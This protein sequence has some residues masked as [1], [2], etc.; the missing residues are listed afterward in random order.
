MAEVHR[1][2]LGEVV[3]PDWHPRFRDGTCPILCFAIAHSDGIVVVD[4]GPRAGHPLIDEWFS[5]KI[6]SIVDALNKVE[7]DEREVTAVVNTHLHFDHCGQNEFLPHAPVWVTAEEIEA[8]GAE[9][10]TN[11]EWAAIGEG[12][13]RLSRDDEEIADGVRILHTPGHTPGHQS[14]AVDTTRGLE[15]IVGQACYGCGEFEIGRP[16]ET[17]M[18]DAAWFKPGLESLRRLKSLD[19]VVS[20]FSHDVAIFRR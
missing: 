11:P 18:H 17:D 20:H 12:R 9:H 6:I 16:A 10:Y 4:T 15:L 14:V 7:L 3:L 2:E 13:R 5:P 19:P 8:A 1:L